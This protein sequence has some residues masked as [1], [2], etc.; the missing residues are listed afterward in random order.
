[1]RKYDSI[2]WVIDALD[3]DLIEKNQEKI[4]KQMNLE[5]MKIYGG[6]LNAV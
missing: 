4:I 5:Q 3:N 6:V 2:Q 1:M